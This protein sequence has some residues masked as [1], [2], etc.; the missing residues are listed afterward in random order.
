ML[1]QGV[2]WARFIDTIEAMVRHAHHTALVVSS[3]N[4]RSST[5]DDSFEPLVVRNVEPAPDDF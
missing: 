3:P 2:G 1:Y 4:G 5:I